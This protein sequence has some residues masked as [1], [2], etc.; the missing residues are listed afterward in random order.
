MRKIFIRG[1]RREVIRKA[2]ELAKVLSGA[3]TDTSG[4]S[5]GFFLAVGYAVLSDVKEAFLVKSKGGVDAMG[6]QWPPLKPET[7][8]RRR[9]GQRDKTSDQRIKR[10]QQLIANMRRKKMREVKQRLLLSMDEQAADKRAKEIVDT[11]QEKT[12]R[13]K[14]ASRLVSATKTQTLGQRDVEMLRDTGVLLNSLSP[15]VI[16]PGGYSPGGKP[17]SDKQIFDLEAGRVTVGTNVPYAAKHNEG[18]ATMKL[19]QRRFLPRRANEVPEVWAQRWLDAA[20]Q[21]LEVGAEMYFR[22]AA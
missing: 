21:A 9:V 1:R 15:G 14:E 12:R 18:D 3:K 16:A 7:I 17:G 22:E 4:I 10:R 13:Q 6:I 8:A 11:P 2:R 5:K 19:P 20:A